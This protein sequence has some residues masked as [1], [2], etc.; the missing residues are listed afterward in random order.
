MQCFSDILIINSTLVIF[1]HIC[2][3]ISG[4]LKCRSFIIYFVASVLSLFTQHQAM[5]IFCNENYLYLTSILY[6]LSKC[7][8][9]NYVLKMVYICRSSIKYVVFLSYFVFL[10]QERNTSYRLNHSTLRV[11]I[12]EMHYTL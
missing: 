12:K 11:R 4:N 2:Q 9:L 7:Y 3:A 6:T 1:R 5:L 8:I 10:K